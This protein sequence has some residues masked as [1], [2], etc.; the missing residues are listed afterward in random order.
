MNISGESS[1]SGKL[2]LKGSSKI[3]AD[4]FEFAINSILFQRGI[5][6]EE[7]FITVRKWDLQML[8]SSD[9]DV[10]EYIQ[11]IM[12]QI[13]KWIY[14]KRICKLVV[15]IVSKSS[16]ETIERWEFDV[17]IVQDE[18]EVGS[19][20]GNKGIEQVQREIQAIVRQVTASVTFLPTLD[21][22]EYTFNVLVYTDHEEQSIPMEW[23]DTKDFELEGGVESVSMRNFKTSIHEVGTT[24]K[25]KTS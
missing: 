23:C 20:G 10:R 25:Y 5:Y 4:Y 17:N 1:R 16:S 8:V 15:A 18:E 22:D 2:L 7:D 12:K 6:P 21:D 11:L 24:V 13:R 3:V 9:D 19:S 14:G